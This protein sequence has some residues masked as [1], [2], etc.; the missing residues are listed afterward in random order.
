MACGYRRF[1]SS[2]GRLAEYLFEAAIQVQ[3]L[4]RNSS[5]ADEQGRDS[6]ATTAE[7]RNT[8]QL[9]RSEKART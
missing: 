1:C 8:S 2:R 7:R 6:V 5:K 4:E 9:A 3:L